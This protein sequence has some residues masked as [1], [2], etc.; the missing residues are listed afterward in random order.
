MKLIEY[1]VNAS[2]QEITERLKYL[3]KAIYELHTIKDEKSGSGRYAVGNLADIE[4]IDGDITIDSFHEKYDYLNSG[5]YDQAI[6]N[7]IIQMCCIGICAYCRLSDLHTSK[8]FVQ[9]VVENIEMY[10]EKA[11]MPSEM[12]QYY[13]DVFCQEKVTYL[14]LFLAD[15]IKEYNDNL[16]NRSNGMGSLV[17]ATKIGEMMTE[18]PEMKMELIEPY[19]GTTGVGKSLSKGRGA[20]SILLLPALLALIYL[21]AIVVYFVFIK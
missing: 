16:A 11:S 2:N 5:I 21:L 17:K 6:N 18:N 14:N 10:L 20:A 19:L 1:F 15:K 3:D 12:Q 7:N 8:E 4:I 13:I 9:D